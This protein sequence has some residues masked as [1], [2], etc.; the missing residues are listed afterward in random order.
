MRVPKWVSITGMLVA[1]FVLWLLLVAGTKLI[2][3]YIPDHSAWADVPILV[4]TLSAVSYP[5][6]TLLG[7]FVFVLAFVPVSIAAYMFLVL[8]LGCGFFHQACL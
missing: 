5:A 6:R 3:G 7:W 4:G 2:V 1:P 8:T